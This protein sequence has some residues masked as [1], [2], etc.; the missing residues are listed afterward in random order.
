M[1]TDISIHTA[2]LTAYVDL[3]ADDMLKAIVKQ[4]RSLSAREIVIGKTTV[5]FRTHRTF[6]EKMTLAP[7][8]TRA[9]MRRIA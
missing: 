7:E 4:A 2:D 9:L 5:V 3:H 6:Y 1:K 8:Y